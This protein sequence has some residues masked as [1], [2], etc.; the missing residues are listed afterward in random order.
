MPK[1]ENRT[2]L[3][4]ENGYLLCPKC[5]RGRHLLRVLP[6]TVAYNQPVFCDRCKREL[7]VDVV[8]ENVYYNKP[9]S[10]ER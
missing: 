1:Y 10:P 7:L 3:P 4:V 6:I 8:K 9:E 5:R 2:S